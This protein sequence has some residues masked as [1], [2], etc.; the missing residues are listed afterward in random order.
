MRRSGTALVPTLMAFTG[1]REGLAQ[2]RFTPIVAAKAREALAHLGQAA[3]AARAAGV[4]VVFGTDAA[5]YRAWPQCRGVRA[6]G[7]AWRDEPG[8]GDR[9]GDDRRGAAARPGE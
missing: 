3:R 5:V 8:R 1:V 6:A 7:R 4:P 2:N 9:L